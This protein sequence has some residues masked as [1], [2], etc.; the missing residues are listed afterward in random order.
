MQR[1]SIKI[2]VWYKNKCHLLNTVITL[3][4]K[5]LTTTAAVDILF[6]LFVFFRE[7]MVWHL[8]WIIWWVLFSQKITEKNKSKSTPF[9]VDHFHKWVKP[10][11]LLSCEFF[12][13]SCLTFN[14]RWNILIESPRSLGL[15]HW[16]S[17]QKVLASVDQSDADW[18]QE[19]TG[20][21][22]A[23]SGNIFWGRFFM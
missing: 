7:N 22:L 4:L 3:T 11:W 2:Y 12:F 21:I 16:A 15:S 23:S 14:L 20:S 5:V 17:V 1:E 10:F 8:Q 6:F 13:V 18:D 19:V 9:R